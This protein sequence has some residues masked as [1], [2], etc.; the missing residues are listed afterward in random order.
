MKKVILI[1]GLCIVFLPTTSDAQLKGLKKNLQKAK[2]SISSKVSGK[3]STPQKTDLNFA[4][5]PYMPTVAWYSLLEA[6]NISLDGKL[7]MIDELDVYFLPDKTIAGKKV[8]FRSNY[9]HENVLWADVINVATQ[10]NM[11]TLHFIAYDHSVGPTKTTM[12][13]H[14]G[15]QVDDFTDFVQLKEGKYEMHFFAGG[16]HYYTFPFEV[17]K[18]TS[19]NAYAAMSELYFLEGDNL[20]RDYAYLKLTYNDAY[21]QNVLS[22]A[23]YIENEDTNV[24]DIDHPNETIP[25]EYNAILKRGNKLLGTLFWGSDVQKLNDNPGL[26]DGDTRRGR[27]E[28]VSR[29]FQSYP[30]KRPKPRPFEVSMEEDLQD[31]NYTI[32][33]FINRKDQPKEKRIFPFTVKDGKIQSL[34]E[35]QRTEGYDSKRMLEQ[36]PEYIFLKR[37]KY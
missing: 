19:D 1:I 22:F 34:P 10:E 17:F 33:V 35:S 29:G 13:Q 8:N 16:T 36:G 6:V 21:N 15:T 23:Y 26:H 12:K 14:I 32:E 27:W 2:S 30:R 28:I 5:K 11:G 18:K 4:S 24:I 31:G 3:S 37:A 20:W 9:V 7:A 25:V